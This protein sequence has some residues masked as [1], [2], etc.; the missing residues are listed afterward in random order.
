LEAL[1]KNNF[2]RPYISSD[3]IGVQV[4]GALKNVMALGIGFLDG[5]GYTDNA[6]AFIFTRGLQEM[7]LCAAA[8]GGK[9]ETLFGLAGV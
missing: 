2:F 9:K 5:A 8:L 7:M 1:F 6:K 3:I 4:G